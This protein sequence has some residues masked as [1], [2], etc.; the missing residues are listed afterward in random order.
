MSYVVTRIFAKTSYLHEKTEQN[1][2]L[3]LKFHMMLP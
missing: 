1:A 2:L 3:R